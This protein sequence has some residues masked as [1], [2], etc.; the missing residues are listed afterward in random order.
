MEYEI[1]QDMVNARSS[2]LAKAATDRFWI[3]FFQML[4]GEEYK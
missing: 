3:D 4:L 2:A 1:T